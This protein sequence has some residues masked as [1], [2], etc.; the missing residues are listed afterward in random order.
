LTHYSPSP[1][2]KRR[3]GGDASRAPRT[4][5]RFFSYPGWQKRGGM[6][7]GFITR[8][9]KDYAEFRYHKMKYEPLLSLD[10]PCY[11]V[12]AH[13]PDFV[14]NYVEDIKEFLDEITN[15]NMDIED[16]PERLVIVSIT[17]KDT[18]YRKWINQ[19]KKHPNL[20]STVKTKS[21]HAPYYPCYMFTLERK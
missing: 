3:S 18:A 8:I 11:S 2:R 14:H 7:N 13:T 9:N 12:R 6:S 4:L 20:L 16:Y 10:L 21:I 15:I 19:I 17:T 5:A 1:P